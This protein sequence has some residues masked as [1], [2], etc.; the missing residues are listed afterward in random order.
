MKLN[1]ILEEFKRE[2]KTLYGPRLKKV[3]LYGSW[4]RGEATDESDIDVLLVLEGT[5]RPGKEIDRIIDIITEIN[6]NYGVVLSVYPIAEK[7]YATVNSPLLMNVRK[8]GI[9]A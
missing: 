3:I 1:P 9:P 8:E 6:L 5:V 7:D 2:L 4:A